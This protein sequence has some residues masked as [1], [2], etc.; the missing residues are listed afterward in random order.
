MRAAIK[1]SLF[2]QTLYFN[3]DGFYQT[4]YEYVTSPTGGKAEMQSKGLEI[5]L[6]YQPDKHFSITSNFTYL[7]ANY[8]QVAPYEQTGI[9]LPYLETFPG[10]AC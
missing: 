6:D 5:D 1:V 8:H 4:R 9:E 3:I 2:K 10:A 7:L